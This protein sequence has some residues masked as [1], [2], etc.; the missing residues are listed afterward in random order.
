MSSREDEECMIDADEATFRQNFV[1]AVLVLNV[2]PH[3]NLVP[4]RGRQICSPS[5]RDLDRSN[6]KN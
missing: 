2:S 1:L 5:E 3:V 6:M 4:T